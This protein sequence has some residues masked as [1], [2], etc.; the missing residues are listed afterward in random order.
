MYFACDLRPIGAHLVL[1]IRVDTSSTCTVFSR[2][3]PIRNAVTGTNFRN[4]GTH[5]YICRSIT[6]IRS[7]ATPFALASVVFQLQLVVSCV[8][9]PVKFHGVVR[10]AIDGKLHVATPRGKHWRSGKS[11]RECFLLVLTF[12]RERFVVFIP[13]N[14]SLILVLRLIIR[15]LCERKHCSLGYSGI[16]IG[17]LEQL[18][19]TFV[20]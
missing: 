4:L 7:V 16:L 14:F 9:G 11:V 18:I 2:L 12:P 17:R 5:V 8:R 10:R 19:D 6:D 13:L 20:K 1:A 3:P 15:T